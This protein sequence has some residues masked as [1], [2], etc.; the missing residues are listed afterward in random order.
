[1][2]NLEEKILK[3]LEFDLVW[4]SPLQ[5]LERFQRLF[6][7]DQ[8]LHDKHSYLIDS[9]AI[10]LCRFMLR[11]VK[12]LS[13]KPS[14]I[15]VAAFMLA[16]NANLETPLSK[17]LDVELLDKQ[18]INVES[19][20]HDTTIRIRINGQ[21]AYKIPRDVSKPSPNEQE[22]RQKSQRRKTFHPTPHSDSSGSLEDISGNCSGSFGDE[23]PQDPLG[24][25]ADTI[26]EL[27]RLKRSSHVR[28]A[29]T[30]LLDSLSAR[31]FGGKLV[32]KEN[33]DL[34]IPRSLSRG[35]GDR[36]TTHGQIKKKSA[37]EAAFETADDE[38]SLESGF[39]E[40]CSRNMDLLVSE[41]SSLAERIAS[42]AE[43][44][45]ETRIEE[46]E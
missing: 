15:A 29:Y 22:K 1:M 10:Y 20:F 13:F 37:R 23:E 28:K 24:R 7:L 5:F 3:A 25:W 16:L 6:S 8:V 35:C 11:D 39:G 32:D 30:A 44:H 2:V 41:Q 45:K 21:R 17:A 43:E 9:S 31:E 33:A 18:F 4:T 19:Y 36:K 40:A 26:E 34:I 12:F 46:Q 27:T 14:Q 38:P 42:V